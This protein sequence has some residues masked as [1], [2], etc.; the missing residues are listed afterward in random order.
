MQVFDFFAP[1]VFLP[2]VTLVS[3]DL[4]FSLL[5]AVL[6]LARLLLRLLL[7]H[8]LYFIETLV[9]GDAVRLGGSLFENVL[10][11]RSALLHLCNL[12]RIA[13]HM[14]LLKF[15]FF[16]LLQRCPL[17]DPVEPLARLVLSLLQLGFL[18]SDLVA[19]HRFLLD[20]LRLDEALI[21]HFLQ[22]SLVA[23][24]C[25]QL[26]ILFV[27]LKGFLQLLVV[28]LSLQPFALHPLSLFLAGVSQDLAS[29]LPRL[30]RP[31][32]PT[33]L[34]LHFPLSYLMLKS[35]IHLLS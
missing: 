27:S 9:S 17:L 20:E 34:F 5:D 24:G 23:L 12:L 35:S 22:G 8:L 10:C 29:R 3:L 31:L 32:H 1:L 14:L 25:D 16:L 30:L 18:Y 7:L 11:K 4:L 15:L 2:Q 19:D 13:Q 33:I 6:Y 28:G 26:P 21:L